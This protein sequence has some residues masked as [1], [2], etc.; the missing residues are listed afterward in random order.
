M[1]GAL[2]HPGA[3]RQAAERAAIKAPA[4]CREKGCVSTIMHTKSDTTAGLNIGIISAGGCCLRSV[5]VWRGGRAMQAPVSFGAWLKQRRKALDLTCE[6]LAQQVGCAVVTLRKL[7]IDARRP[8]RQMAERLAEHLHLSPAERDAFVA[9]ARSTQFTGLVSPAPAPL[10]PA[11]ATRTVAPP[12]LPGS[13]TPLIGRAHEVA[14]VTLLI[15][16]PDVRLVTLTGVGGTGKTRLAF[17]VAADLRSDYAD[18]ASFVD[19]DPLRAPDLVAAT[20][21]QTLGIKEA[22]G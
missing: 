15:Q 12:A 22:G 6:E 10:R 8:S 4:G 13:L 16:R 5:V 9:A 3:T 11:V 20:I 21:A 17:Q 2:R 1:C 7:E 14:A 19:L 18:G